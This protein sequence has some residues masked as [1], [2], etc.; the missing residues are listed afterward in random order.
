M[1]MP[2]RSTK[3][4][5]YEPKYTDSAG[6]EVIKTE[7][8]KWVREHIYNW[9]KV[10]GEVPK[11]Y[12]LIF[13]DENKKNTAVENLEMVQSKGFNRTVKKQEGIKN[14]VSELLA[15]K[16]N[17]IQALK[18]TINLLLETIGKSS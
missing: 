4:I 16:D 17:E 18:D 3:F 6:F 8:G 9:K 5:G 10:N 7:D 2:R 15:Q 14:N 11:G 1:K 13:K 12:F